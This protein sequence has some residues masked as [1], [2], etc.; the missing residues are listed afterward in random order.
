MN[1]VD[2]VRIIVGQKVL[3]TGLPSCR[4]GHRFQL[5]RVHPHAIKKFF[6]VMLANVQLIVIQIQ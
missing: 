3:V 5:D 2:I 4:G 1:C 6:C